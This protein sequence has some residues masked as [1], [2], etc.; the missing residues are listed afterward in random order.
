M[1]LLFE[2]YLS[3]GEG[4]GNPLLYFCLGNPMESLVGYS[5]WGRKRARHNLATKQQ[6]SLLT[7][8]IVQYLEQGMLKRGMKKRK[9]K[10]E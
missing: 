9:E 6:Q 2:K 4:N 10:N 7:D 1:D 5:P 3:P 8:K